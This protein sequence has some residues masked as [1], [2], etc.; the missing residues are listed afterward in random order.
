LW[1]EIDVL[2]EGSLQRSRSGKAGMNDQSDTQRKRSGFRTLIGYR[3]KVWR[4]GYGEVELEIGPQHLNS[5]GIVHGGIYAAL[6]DVALGH[7]VSFCPVPGHTRYS[8]TVS[9]TTAFLNAADTGIL[10][11]VGRTEGLSGRLVTASGEVRTQAGALLATAQGSFLY[12]PGSEQPD[13]VPK[14]PR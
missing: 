9:L 5:I 7:A 1:G 13:G 12:F 6:L 2:E 3:T 11:A 4:E 8:T 10:T 14:R